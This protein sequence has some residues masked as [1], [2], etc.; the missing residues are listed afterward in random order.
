MKKYVVCY[1]DGQEWNRMCARSTMRSAVI[2]RNKYFGKDSII[3]P[4]LKI[5]VDD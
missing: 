1:F 2:A 4:D 3:R 5:I